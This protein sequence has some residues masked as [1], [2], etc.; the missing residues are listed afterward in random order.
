MPHPRQELANGEDHPQE[1]S[2]QDP[3]EQ[4]PGI[5]VKT[6]QVVAF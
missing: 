5:T 2:N 3:S 1:Q 4:L 6:G